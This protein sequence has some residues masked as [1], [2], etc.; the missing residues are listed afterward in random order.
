MEEPS[1]FH[2]GSSETFSI[3][4]VR[5]WGSESARLAMERIAGVRM[6]VPLHVLIAGAVDKT[7]T[8]AA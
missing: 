5:V 6:R 8:L 3:F 4:L 2:S 7:R 1:K